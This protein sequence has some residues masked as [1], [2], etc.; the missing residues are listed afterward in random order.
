MPV[1]FAIDDKNDASWI[2]YRSSKAA[3]SDSCLNG[4]VE[5]YESLKAAVAGENP[6]YTFTQEGKNTVTLYGKD[7]AK[8]CLSEPVEVT[9]CIDKSAP[10]WAD[11]DGVADGYGIQIK[12][13]WFRSL[14]NT[15]SFGYLYNDAM[16]M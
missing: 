8:G 5:I 12:E 15:I 3:A 1:S 4:S 6:G 2:L 13:N 14:L 9:I 11:K 7:T 10:T 16:E